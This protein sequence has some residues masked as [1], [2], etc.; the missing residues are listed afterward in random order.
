MHPSV[1]ILALLISLHLMAALA[2]PVHSL[3]PNSLQF[4]T[5]AKLTSNA[6]NPVDA[7]GC[8]V[9]VDGDTLVIGGIGNRFRGY[10]RG[11]AYVYV[12][13]GEGWTLQQVLMGGSEDQTIEDG[14]GGSVAISGD[15][16]VVGANSDSS[17]GFLAGAAY[18]Y[19]R[20][21]A[22]WSLQQKLTASDA[23]PVG[24]LG[25]SV[26]IQGDTIVAGA[27]GDDDAGYLT[28]AAYIFQRQGGVWSEQQ[29][30]KASDEA[31]DSVFGQSVAVFNDTIAVGSPSHS[32]PTVHYSGAVYVFGRGSSGWN[33]QQQITTRDIAEGQWLGYCVDLSG[34][35]LVATA[36]GDSVGM[37][38][39]GAAYVFSLRPGGWSEQRK[40]KDTDVGRYDGFALRAAIDGDR[41]VLGDGTDNTAATW[42]GA[43]H[44]Y[45]RNGNTGWSLQQTL[46]AADAANF[47]LLGSAVA[48]SGDT[49][50][51]GVTQKDDFRGA[52]YV[53]R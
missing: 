14:F 52:A 12:R 3:P 42:G 4:S 29:K 21:G 30:L 35:T 49:I 10:P 28:G 44:V 6:Q 22:T 19:V 50:V 13:D 51:V 2:M 39:H 20:S 48:I 24:V 33:E 38:T 7:F 16:I 37:H 23:S 53:F 34:D 47:D 31:E 41:I 8:A 26:A 17:A 40:L 1:R 46:T 45:V 27:P 15:T 5:Q 32:T 25:L 18:V 9:D 11:A 36:P 43:A